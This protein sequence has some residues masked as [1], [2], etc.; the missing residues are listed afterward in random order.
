MAICYETR[1]SFYEKKHGWA[2]SGTACFDRPK[3]TKQFMLTFM[4]LQ[5][6]FGYQLNRPS[7]WPVCKNV[8]PLSELFLDMSKFRMK[9][10]VSKTNHGNSLLKNRI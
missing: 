6:Q 5:V 10:Q 3:N 8:V 9:G 1:L 2:T 7:Y 4:D